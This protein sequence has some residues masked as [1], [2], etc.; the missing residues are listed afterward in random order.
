M[1]PLLPLMTFA[2]DLLVTWWQ[3]LCTDSSTV[4]S[5]IVDVHNEFRRNVQPPA[6][7][8]LQMEW[9][10][11]IVPSIQAWVDGCVLHHGE[12]STRMLNGYE[13][14]ENLFKSSS[15]VSWTSV[16]TAWHSEVNNF[17]YPTSSKNGKV[18]GHYTQVIW[19]SSYRVGCA[20]AKCPDD[21]YFYGCRY[22]RAGNFK[23]WKP[24]TK[25][26]S[27]G[28]CPN[29]C[30][31]KLCTNPCPYINDYLNCL[32]LSPAQCV[33]PAVAKHCKA[34]CQCSNQIIPVGKR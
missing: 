5:E 20:M 9:G 26:E 3:G 21:I 1:F 10:D 33:I 23:G 7:D 8:M 22:Y 16:V 19:N 4:Q 32:D 12:P 17:Q 27:C 28:M 15:P 14:G 11:E 31:N 6:Q 25:G 29:N 18:I 30:V 34:L 24:Y 13:L 2:A